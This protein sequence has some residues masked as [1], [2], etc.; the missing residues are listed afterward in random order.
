MDDKNPAPPVAPGGWLALTF[1]LLIYV[2]S[3]MDR[4]ILSALG[5]PIKRELGLSDTQLGLLGG[6]AFALTYSILG[7]PFAR[8]AERRSRKMIIV[9]V[10]AIWS[11][12]TALCGFAQGF[13]QLLAFRA[14]VGLGEAGFTAPAH[15][16]ISDYFPPRSTRRRAIDF[17]SRHSPR[18]PSRR[19]RRGMD[20]SFIW[21]AMGLCCGWFAGAR[22]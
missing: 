7:V 10:V 20:Y 15:A 22:V 19:A 13:A 14:F 11:A 4:T 1:L 2:S 3:F 5:E 6:L 16:L 9:V 8:L 17:L 21:L 18:S 12:M